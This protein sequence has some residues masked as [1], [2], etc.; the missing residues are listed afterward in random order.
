MNR[1]RWK[2]FFMESGLCIDKARLVNWI[3]N[4]PSWHVLLFRFLRLRF[5][6]AVLEDAREWGDTLEET[7]KVFSLA[8]S[9]INIGDTYKTTK[10]ERTP[11]A[12]AA[13][14]R[15]A[16]E[17]NPK[18]L[19]VGVSD[20]TS[21]IGLLKKSQR[22]SKILLT[23]RHPVFY[24]KRFPFGSVFLDG[25]KRFLGIKI[26]C[27]YF[28]TGSQNL[29]NNSGFDAI[30]TLNPLVS[31]E[32]SQYSIIPFNAAEDVFQEEVDIIKCANIL[33]RSYF[34]EQQLLN[35]TD[36]LRHSLAEGGYLVISQNNAKYPQGE[37]VVVLKKSNDR[38]SI[39]SDTNGH[40]VTPIFRKAWQ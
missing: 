16:K 5:S 38:F 1:S 8:I 19:E 26:L 15:L 29:R 11:I 28:T 40:D 14:L 36:N 35:L 22:F 4:H 13:I 32:Y 21:A 18:L 7:A 6:P 2:H 33:N 34:N 30:A 9:Y 3:H 25:D 23:D 37:A 31:S 10:R 12:D 17:T 39:E 27:F 20:A 24:R